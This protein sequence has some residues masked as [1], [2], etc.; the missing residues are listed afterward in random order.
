MGMHTLKLIA[1]GRL[2]TAANGTILIGNAFTMEVATDTNQGAAMHTL[3]LI[4]QGRLSTAAK[5]T[6]LI[7]NAFTMEVTT[8]A[9]T[10]AGLASKLSAL[11]LMAANG[12]IIRVAT[13]MMATDPNQTIPRLRQYGLATIPRPR[14]QGP[15]KW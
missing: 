8:E 14:Q 11:R 10:I 3:K 13:T 5:G 6:I 1:Q 15:S 12:T 7:G 2:S 9:K 4:A